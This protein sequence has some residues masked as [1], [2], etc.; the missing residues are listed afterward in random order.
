MRIEFPLTL[1][2]VQA[3]DK[4]QWNI[5]NA[6][7]KEIEPSKTGVNDKSFKK[8]VACSEMLASQGFNLSPSTLRNLRDVTAAFPAARRRGGVGVSIHQAAGT[9][10]NLDQAIEALEK[11]RKPINRAISAPAVFKRTV[12]FLLA[13]FASPLRRARSTGW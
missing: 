7:L 12:G 11:L 10:D 1:A 13:A 2:A 4:S 8:F 5:G 3:G 6:L 9:P